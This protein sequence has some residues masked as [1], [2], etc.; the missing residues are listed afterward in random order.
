MGWYF[1]C[2]SALR[3]KARTKWRNWTEPGRAHWSLVDA[4]GVAENARLENGGTSKLW[5]IV[6]PTEKFWP[7]S[8]RMLIA[9]FLTKCTTWFKTSNQSL[10][11]PITRTHPWQLQW[12]RRHGRRRRRRRSTHRCCTTHSL[13]APTILRCAWCASSH[14]AP[15]SHSCHVVMHASAATVLT[16]SHL[17]TA[18]AR[19][20]AVLSRWCCTCSTELLNDRCQTWVC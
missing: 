15:T 3:L 13:S 20:A 17:W 19:Y 5:N 4:Y 12:R 8:H 1:H 10:L 6:R 11:W 9:L 18:A 2:L 16:Q 7:G 14:N